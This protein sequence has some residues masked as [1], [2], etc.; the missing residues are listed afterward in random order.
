MWYWPSGIL[1]TRTGA[2]ISPAVALERCIDAAVIRRSG[3][4]V[5]REHVKF[6]D[7]RIRRRRRAASAA[8]GFEEVAAVWSR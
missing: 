5:G 7:R 4:V 3:V 8:L 2:N 6:A 1:L